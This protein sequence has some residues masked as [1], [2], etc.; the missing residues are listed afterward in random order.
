MRPGYEYAIRN[1]PA[2]YET[3]D[4][5]ATVTPAE[6]RAGTM[7]QRRASWQGRGQSGRGR[8][9]MPQRPADT[10][11][12]DAELQAMQLRMRMLELETLRY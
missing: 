12:D 2:G 4:Y 7:A 3:S 9:A 6:T 8:A 11:P 1:R 10:G 5:A